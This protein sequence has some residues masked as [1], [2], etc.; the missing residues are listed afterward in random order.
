MAC[1]PPA[2]SLR[3]EAPE[4]GAELQNRRETLNGGP[5]Q[6][7]LYEFFGEAATGGRPDCHRQKYA[8]NN[9][10]CDGQA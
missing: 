9:Q 1:G 3:S 6:K 2:Y 4:S 5:G 10:A 8:A 7:V